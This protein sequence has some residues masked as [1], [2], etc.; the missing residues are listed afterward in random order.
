MDWREVQRSEAKRRQG[1][2]VMA[3]GGV[4]CGERWISQLRDP[5]N[6]DDEQKAVACE[7]AD[8]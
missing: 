7:K 4:E 2:K 6:P 1:R 3:D 8:Q 5:A